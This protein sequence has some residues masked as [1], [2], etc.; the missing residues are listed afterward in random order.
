M[1]E[2]F[3]PGKIK[4]DKQE[5]SIS[6]KDSIKELIEPFVTEIDDE[7]V[8]GTDMFAIAKI[9]DDSEDDILEM[10]RSNNANSFAC[11]T[12][13]KVVSEM[14]KLNK[15]SKNAPWFETLKNK[16]LSLELFIASTDHEMNIEQGE[17]DIDDLL[18]RAGED[19]RKKRSDPDQD[20]PDKK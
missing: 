2:R 6:Y 17:K 5:T 12:I 13:I 16:M 3:K 1:E 9:L 15:I 18:K 4:S 10:L 20:G 14:I 11:S 19:F 8:W 7:S